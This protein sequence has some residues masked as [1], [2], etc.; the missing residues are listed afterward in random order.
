MTLVSGQ[1]RRA[2][3]RCRAAA[4]P[5]PSDASPTSA[6]AAAH[7]IPATGRNRFPPQ[8]PDFAQRELVGRQAS[9]QVPSR[10]A[11]GQLTG[12]ERRALYGAAP[13]ASRARLR[14]VA[15]AMGASAHP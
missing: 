4:S 3:R 13:P 2:S 15:K 1:G 5:R 8:R 14:R 11:K 12:P 6:A 9:R 10:R 7:G